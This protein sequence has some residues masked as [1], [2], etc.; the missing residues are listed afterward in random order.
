MTVALTYVVLT[1]I[2]SIFQLFLAGFAKR[3]QDGY[4]W[5]AGNRDSGCPEYT[6][7]AGRATRAQANLLETLPAFIGAVLIAHV[8]GHDTTLTAW[9][10][11][12]YFWG[13]LFYVPVYAIGLVPWRTV[14]WGV[15]M[16]GLAMVLISII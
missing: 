14:V 4:Q 10:A 9:G 13:R 16:V 6:G 5:A 7:L 8:S 12:L 15:A 3:Q 1:I 11:A 2:L